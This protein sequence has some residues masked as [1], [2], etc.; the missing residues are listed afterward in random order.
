MRPSLALLALSVSASPALAQAAPAPH[1]AIQ[2]PPDTAERVT[3]AMQSVSKAVQ[4]LAGRDDP[5]ET[6]RIQQQIAAAQPQ[7][8]QSIRAVN[9]AIPQIQ[10]S[11][12]RRRSPSSGRS[13][14][15]PIQTIRSARRARPMR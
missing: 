5:I 2:L 14:I 6:R 12:E 8:E 1:K 7:I 10:R 11:L 15:C 3:N 9:E 4:D 13:Q